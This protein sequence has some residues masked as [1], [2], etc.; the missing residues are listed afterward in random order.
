[1]GPTTGE[2]QE[3]AHL[4]AE[5]LLGTCDDLPDGT[6]DDLELCQHL[7]MLVLLCETC[8]WWVETSDT[9]EDGNCSDCF[10][11]GGR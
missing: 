8:G 9:D 3:Q 4:L 1:M 10:R 5:A 6:T 2:V 11:D 7:D